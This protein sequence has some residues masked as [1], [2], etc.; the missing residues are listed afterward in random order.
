MELSLDELR[1]YARC[2]LE[3][4]WEKRAG[5]PRPRTTADLMPEAIRIALDSFYRGK[6]RSLGEAVALVWKTWCDEWGEPSLSLKLAQYATTRASLLNQIPRTPG[7]TLQMLKWKQAYKSKMRVSGLHDAGQKL[8]RVARSC[9]LVVPDEKGRI[10]GALGDAFADCLV[11]V[12][13]LEAS[14]YLLPHRDRV[15]GWQMPYQIELG[16]DLR[17]TGLA[18]LVWRS[19]ADDKA[20][21]LEV[22]DYQ[23]LAWVRSRLVKHDLRV[24]AAS[25]AQPTSAS[26]SA[27]W[28]RVEAVL[29]RHW[30]SGVTIRCNGETDL[31]A[32]HA[33]LT[34]AARGMQSQIFIP[35]SLSGY[36]S[37]RT[38]AHLS[39]CWDEGLE[40]VQF[41]DYGVIGPSEHL[42][43][44]MA[45]LRQTMAGEDLA[46][47]RARQGLEI[48]TRAFDAIGPDPV[49]INAFIQEYRH[50]L[51][52]TLNAEK[53]L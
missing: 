12:D 8:D 42:R 10:G 6:A 37:C 27:H 3:W 43:A 7:D 18:D 14:R 26:G 9:G 16:H 51:E 35:R 20:I 15:L 29:F 36:D 21:V 13:G 48:M 34:S 19:D 52:E 1:L 31:G 23:N 11:A 4:F 30:P 28:E 25:L 22:H 32:L 46:A 2:P 33:L 41:V 50:L 49:S 53:P 5:Y 24:I 40:L 17:L 38:C 44:A 45:E 47:R 39:R